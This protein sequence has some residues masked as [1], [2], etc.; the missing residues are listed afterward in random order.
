MRS[1]VLAT[2]LMLCASVGVVSCGSPD[3][4]PL[5]VAQ[6]FVTAVEAADYAKAASLTSVP[7]RHAGGPVPTAA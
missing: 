7:R 6:Q 1:R 5:P 3:P 4:K 2:A